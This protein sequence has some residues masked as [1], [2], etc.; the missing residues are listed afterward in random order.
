MTPWL[1]ALR[2]R[3][4]SAGDAFLVTILSVRGSAPREPGAKML[5]DREGIT[6]T[7]GGGILE[8]R[9]AKL[10]CDV[11]GE[12]EPGRWTALTHKFPLG[13]GMGQCCGGVVEVLFERVN[14]STD[15]IHHLLECHEQRR[16]AVI[17][18]EPPVDGHCTKLVVTADGF[19]I[20]GT[21]SVQVHTVVN[22]ARSLLAEC[23]SP[24]RVEATAQ[25]G[26]KFRLLLEPFG[27]PEMSIALFGAGHVG[28][29]VVAAMASLNCEIRWIDSRRSVFPATA[30]GNVIMIESGEPVREVAAMPPGAYYLVMTH[31]HPLDFEICA[32]ALRRDDFAYV[33]L[34]GSRTKRRRFEQRMKEA[35][36]PL[37]LLDR[38]ACPMG[39]A[40]VGG[41]RPAEIAIAV[42]AELLK[43]QAA[44]TALHAGPTENT[45]NVHVL[46]R[47]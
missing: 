39:I 4:P 37:A 9:C 24:R 8:H 38:L 33:G 25:D 27:S 40:G 21:A 26:S 47:R 46:R 41:K 28:S 11:L 12:L 1:E 17:A 36:L 22:L 16:A 29:A 44:I 10:A 14:A 19:R 18:T 2:H 6:G 23:G 35:D 5:V 30:P 31:S 32:A 20:Y 34:I 15:W 7:I 45:D 43:V 3:P 42:A 13:P